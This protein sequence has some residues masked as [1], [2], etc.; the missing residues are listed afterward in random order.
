M[1]IHFT[2]SSVC[3]GD[4]CFDNSKDFE[5]DDTASWEDIMPIIF[6]GSSYH[7]FTGIMLYGYWKTQRTMKSYP[8]LQ[9]RIKFLNVHV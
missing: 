3:M 9:R 5:F 8:F 1:N 7:L 4:D 6:K 2:R